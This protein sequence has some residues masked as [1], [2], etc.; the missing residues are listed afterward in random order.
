MKRREFLGGAAASGAVLTMPA[1]ISGCGIQ[2]ATAV[3]NKTPEN[4]FMDWFGVDQ[5]TT[6]Q[7]MSELSALA[8]ASSSASRRAMHSPKT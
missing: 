8:C 4:P 3:A 7:V 2:Q 5:A 6:A 1:F